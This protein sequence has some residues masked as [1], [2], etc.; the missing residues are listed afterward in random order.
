[1]TKLTI[2]I[3][4]EDLKELLS[5]YEISQAL[6]EDIAERNPDFWAEKIGDNLPSCLKEAD[7]KNLIISIV[8]QRLDFIDIDNLIEDKINN[9]IEREVRN[10]ISEKIRSIVSKFVLEGIKEEK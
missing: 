7:L 6:V 8:E 4:K 9:V 10:A 5:E 3:T 1:M 2:N